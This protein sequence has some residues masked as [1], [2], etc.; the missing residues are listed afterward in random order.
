MD[1]ALQKEVLVDKTDRI[2]LDNFANG[3]YL[4]KL[5]D[6]GGMYEP[7]IQKMVVNN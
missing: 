2:Q 6:E 3:I 7:L 5:S 1:G 4:L